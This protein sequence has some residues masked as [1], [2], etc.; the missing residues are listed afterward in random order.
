MKCDFVSRIECAQMD[1]THRLSA[2]VSE[3]AAPFKMI[4]SVVFATTFPM[5]KSKQKSII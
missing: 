3:E 1:P 4:T 2:C 5:P